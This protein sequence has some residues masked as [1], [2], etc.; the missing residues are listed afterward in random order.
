MKELQ[1]RPGQSAENFCDELVQ[2]A[3]RFGCPI[4]GKHNAVVLVAGP[5]F[6]IDDVMVQWTQAQS[7]D[8]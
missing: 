5:G 6:T 7:R 3:D 8:H 2:L 4:R 1:A